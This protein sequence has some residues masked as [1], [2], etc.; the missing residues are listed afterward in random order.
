MPDIERA[1]R[2]L[3]GNIYIG[4]IIAMPAGGG[5]I[6]SQGGLPAGPIPN[7]VP[8][9]GLSAGPNTVAHGLGFS[10]AAAI[11]QMNSAA[12]IWWQATPWDGTNFYLVASDASA[13]CFIIVWG[14][15]P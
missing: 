14:N 13:T 9:S 10:P 8:I 4:S 7:I 2:R 3:Q 1:R 15:S 6:T 11:I 12:E 5:T